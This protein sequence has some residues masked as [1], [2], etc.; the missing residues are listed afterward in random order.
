MNEPEPDP[1]AAEHHF[2][3]MLLSHETD[4]AGVVVAR[5]YTVGG[6][7]GFHSHSGLQSGETD[8]LRAHIALGDVDK[9]IRINE[10]T[11][12]GSGGRGVVRHFKI[13]QTGG[14]I[15]PGKDGRP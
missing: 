7:A 10:L 11:A 3:V 12:A 6:R 13:I 4:P 14:P 1:A 15:G 9:I 2:D 5:A 8:M